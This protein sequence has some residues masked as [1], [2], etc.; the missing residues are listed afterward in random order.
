MQTL[1]RLL[2]IF[3]SIVL[4]RLRISLSII[5]LFI[6]VIIRY[7]REIVFR[8]FKLFII[9]SYIISYSR[10]IRAR[11]LLFMFF[12]LKPLFTNLLGDF[13]I[14]KTI[15]CELNIHSI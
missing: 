4:L 6:T 13:Y 7:L 1:I 9:R 5:A 15:I 8:T 2:L 14:T 10:D 12:H 3:W 11:V